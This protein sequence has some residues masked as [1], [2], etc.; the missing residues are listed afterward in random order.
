MCAWHAHVLLL[1]RLSDTLAPRAVAVN[2]AAPR[3]QR[4]AGARL[5]RLHVKR[6]EALTPSTPVAADGVPDKPDKNEVLS[7]ALSV[8]NSMLCMLQPHFID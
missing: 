5:A 7:R 8:Y 3:A 4:G 6:I 2:T 1:R